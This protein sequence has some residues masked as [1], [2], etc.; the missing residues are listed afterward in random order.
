MRARRTALILFGIICFGAVL[1]LGWQRNGPNTFEAAFQ[2]GGEVVLDLS[3]GSFTIRGAAENKIWVE[4]EP[5]T[6]GAHSEISV[7][8]TQAKV[9]IEGPSHDFKAVIYVPKQSNL[10]ANQTMGELRVEDVEGN[11]SLGLNIGQIKVVADPKQIKTLDASAKIGEVNAGAWR[12]SHGGFFPS[13]RMNGQ[14]AYSLRAIVDIGQVD[15]R[16]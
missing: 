9:K 8:G 13:F 2:P 10:V 3:V 15:L 11:K 7:K 5:N 1:Y 12:R 14:G 16:D 4:L 6:S